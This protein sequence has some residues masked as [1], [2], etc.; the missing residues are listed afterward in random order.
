MSFITN[1][2]FVCILGLNN[3]EEWITHSKLDGNG[4]LCE[5]KAVLRDSLAY[6]NNIQS[7]N[8]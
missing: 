2:S 8:V 5:T 7:D 3:P 6:K 4:G 1:K